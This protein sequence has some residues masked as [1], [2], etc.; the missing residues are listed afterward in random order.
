[1]VPNDYF[2]TGQMSIFDILT[3]K[4]D[5]REALACSQSPLALTDNQ[6]IFRV[7]KG[8]VDTFIYK[9]DNWTVEKD[10]E[11]ETIYGIQDGYGYGSFPESALGVT[12]F[13][14]AKEAEDKAMQY[15]MK[16][17]NDILVIQPDDIVQTIAWS[18]IRE[19]DNKKM[20]AFIS[21]LKNGMTY[22]KDFYT[23]HHV[24]NKK[25][26]NVVKEFVNSI[27]FKDTDIVEEKNY[28]PN[29]PC[30][31]YACEE[32]NSW[33]FAEARYGGCKKYD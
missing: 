20:I 33:A 2:C 11:M 24:L 31:F 29:A 32:G 6:A 15:V 28:K 23:Y 30:M 3:E 14:N 7:T 26:V 16:H 9:G 5:M 27:N 19:C 13:T 25:F 22:A 18:F 1:M 17:K 12:Y 10:G 8:L 21:E 4:D